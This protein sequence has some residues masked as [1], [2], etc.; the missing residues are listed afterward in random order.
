M[1]A[2]TRALATAVAPG[3]LRCGSPRRRSWLRGCARWDCTTVGELLEHLPRDSR[4]ARTVAAL[5]AGEQATVAVQV[6]SRSPCGRCAVG[7]CARWSR[8][9]SFDA[10]GSMRAT[11]FNQPW[12]AKRYPPGTRLL[13]HGKADGSG[14]LSRLTPRARP[15]A[16][17][18]SRHARVRRRRGA[19][20]HYPAAEGVTST[21]ILTLVQ[22]A[23][24]ALSDVTEALSAAMR[25]AEGLPDRA[26]ALAAMHFPRDPR[27]TRRPGA[28][29]LAFEELLL[30]Q[31]VFLRRRARRR[32]RRG[33]AGAGRGAVAERAL[34]GRRPAVR[35]R[36]A[37]SAGRSRR[38]TRTSLSRARCSG[39]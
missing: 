4:E 28:R 22:G 24:G 12:L 38:S 2:R 15:R 31:L 32:A 18:V 27:A 11:F 34:A 3:R 16:R 25:V 26:S 33:R 37:T 23:R 10:T 14:G 35:A 21:Q 5:R 13:L 7:A 9:R 1:I 36:P 19:V 30:T 8:P 29:R 20:A 17:G 6:R 39:C